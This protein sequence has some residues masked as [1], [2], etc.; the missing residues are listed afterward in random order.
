MEHLNGYIRLFLE[1]GRWDL[2]MAG[3]EKEDDD[4]EG[5]AMALRLAQWEPFEGAPKSRASPTLTF[6]AHVASTLALCNTSDF[7][8]AREYF[9]LA[10]VC[11]T[12]ALYKTNAEGGHPFTSGFKF[13]QQLHSL[14]DVQIAWPKLNKRI[15]TEGQEQA[16]QSLEELLKKWKVSGAYFEKFFS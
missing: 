11:A 12:R 6:D 14:A 5:I 2:I 13:M 15:S 16:P 7:E 1:L 9:E 3:E 8:R 10:E 4:A